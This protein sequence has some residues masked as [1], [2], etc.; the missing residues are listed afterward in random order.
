MNKYGL[1]FATSLKQEKD[2]IFDTILRVISLGFIMFILVQLWSYIYGESGANS[3]INGY[4]LEQMLWYLLVTETVASCAK[5]SQ[6]TRKIGNEIKSGSIAYKINKPYNFYLYNI[7][8]FMAKSIWLLVFMLP[9]ALLIGFVLIGAIE[10][11]TFIQ[12]IPSL[13]VL[14][15]SLLLIWVLYGILGLISF[16]VEDST[17]FTWIMQKF[18]LLFGLLFPLEFFPKSI[19]PI[20]TYSPIYSIY[21]GPA[22]LI[23]SYSF[24]LFIQVLIS[25]LV[26]NFIL[27]AL[28]LFI[29]KKGRKK[30]NANGG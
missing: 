12:I 3:V 14:I 8:D 11:F 7:A 16:W 26:W 27:I 13:L 19:Q 4:T 28:G 25:Q 9:F 24:D 2:T 20:I 6:I 30:V 10:S 21:S 22:K 1:V 5:Q 15:L 17:P 29:Y 23:A 18:L